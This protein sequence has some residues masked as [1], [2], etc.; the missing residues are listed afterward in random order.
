MYNDNLKPLLNTLS[1]ENK[2]DVLSKLNNVDGNSEKVG[3]YM[4]PH[5]RDLGSTSRYH[6]LALNVDLT[7]MMEAFDELPTKPNINA[8][9]SSRR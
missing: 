8:I 2:T 3:V 9:Y 1:L 6:R 4:F 7:I 5:K